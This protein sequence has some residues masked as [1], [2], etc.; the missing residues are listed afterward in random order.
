MLLDAAI[1]TKVCL[2]LPWAAHNVLKMAYSSPLIETPR[3]VLRPWAVTDVD[4]LY[5][6]WTDADVQRYL[7]DDIV[8]PRDRAA[9]TCIFRR[10]SPHLIGFCGFRHI[11]DSP[12]IEILYGLMPGV[13]KQGLA[14]EACTAILEYG[15]TTALF[16]R[17]FGRADVQNQGS[18][19]V[20]ER[21]GM[22]FKGQTMIGNLPT[23][24]Y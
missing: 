21:L 18:V 7:W 8:I 24:V 20:L 16:D 23:L 13:W 2:F 6:L 22:G 19:R 4:G 10:E 15:F 14:F 12:D 3:L 11:E 1:V 5:R 9:E 17:V